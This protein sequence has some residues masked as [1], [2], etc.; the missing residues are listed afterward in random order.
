MKNFTVNISVNGEMDVDKIAQAIRKVIDKVKAKPEPLKVGDIVVITGNSEFYSKG[1]CN[2]IGDIGKIV[3][4]GDQGGSFKIEVPGNPTFANCTHKKEVRRATPD[5]VAQYEEEI[6]QA[7]AEA[8]RKQVES[9]WAEI[10]RKV[11][12]FREGDIV[13]GTRNLG[14]HERIIGEMVDGGKPDSLGDYGIKSFVD[15]GYRS[16]KDIELVTPVESRFDR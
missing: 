4:E 10:G 13:R 11:D 15:G 3:G 9:K 5:E 16:V 6:A 2:G 8:E 12:E 1:S 7:K 14:D